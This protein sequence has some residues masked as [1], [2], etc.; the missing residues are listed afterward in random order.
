M[1]VQLTRMSDG[2]RRVTSIA[3]ITGME[4]DIIQLQEIFKYVRT[5]TAADGT[6]QR[7]FRRDRRASALPL[8][9][10]RQGDQDPRPLLRSQ[11]AAGMMAA[12]TCLRSMPNICSTLFAA[13]AAV[14][15]RR[16]RLSA[17]PFLARRIAIA[18]IAGSRCSTKTP[19]ATMCLFSFA[20]NA[21]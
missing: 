4:G 21:G 5:S 16:S 15:D 11:Q 18:S 1:I 7:P 10:H 6:V 12:R 9:P 3:E 17:V 13:V 8:R 19:V 2:K 20:A 14:P